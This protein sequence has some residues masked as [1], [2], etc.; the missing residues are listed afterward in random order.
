MTDNST[1]YINTTKYSDLESRL[2][3][4]N[5]VMNELGTKNLTSRRL[6]YVEIDIEAERASGKIQPDELII[7]QHVIDTNIR[8]EQSAYVQYD[9]QSPRAVILQ[10]IDNPALDTTIL[11]K[12]V[13]NKLRFDGWQLS[14]FSNI[15][16]MQQN[17]YGAMELVLDQSQP[18]ELAHEYVQLGDLGIVRD[19]KD[20][21]ETE[22][23]T[24]NYYFSKTR[25]LAMCSEEGYKFNKQQVDKVVDQE[26]GTNS[27]SDNVDFS[28]VDKSLYCIQK[29]MFRVKGIVHVAWAKYDC[30]SDWI[31]APR[32][33]YIGRRKAKASPTVMEILKSKL[34]GV[35][36]SEPVFETRY[37]YF[38]FP[39]LISENNTISQLK[40]RA[41]LDQDCQMAV[42]SVVSSYVT[43]IRRAA[44]TYF[45]KDVSD[46]ND[47]LMLQKNVFL[48]QGCLINSKM[49]QFQMQ[50]PPSDCIG[51]VNLLVSQ[52]QNETSQINFAVNNRKDSRKTAT[53]I[54]T[55]N[56][57]AANLSTVQVVL[58]SNASKSLYTTMF[59]II[60]S[61]VNAGL[62][63]VRPELVPMYAQR[64]S[65]RPSG[66]T[67]VIERQQLIQAMMAAWEV[68]SKTPAAVEFLCDLLS[69]MFPE[70][71]ARYCDII[72]KSDQEAKSQSA[73][74]QEQL[75]DG[76]VEMGNKI[77][78]LSK[79]KEYFSEIGLIHA[80]PVIE[81]G[82][83][84]IKQVQE[85][86]EQKQLN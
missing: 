86:Q 61:R 36:V 39:Y 65:V 17:G 15:D 22:M 9:T 45:S 6:R 84:Q 10:N 30:C 75:M 69:K 53:E 31:R 48:K 18:G 34:T 3:D 29:V 24:R 28:Q 33:L 55:A 50:P 72:R 42:Q 2:K 23:L 4:L 64:Y 7:P 78:E 73:Q 59:E 49:T 20:I 41:F 68:M 40:G 67:D 57:Q 16:G 21:Q 85:A 13:T 8:R 14:R 51:A 63:K 80:L 56:Q 1:D 60:Q 70:T 66:D 47:D 77:I 74:Q 19:T 58:Y 27:N 46:P 26:P 38:I 25:L 5:S 71:A 35:P 81:Q 82:A 32:P 76:A 54:S 37:P 44:G 62:V 43:G 52:N 12:D 79:H 83:Y 11:E